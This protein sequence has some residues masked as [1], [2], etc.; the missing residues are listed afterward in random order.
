MTYYKVFLLVLTFTY[1]HEIIHPQ[2]HTTIPCIQGDELK[3]ASTYLPELLL[4]CT[5]P[6]DSL[7]DWG[8]TLS[9]CIS[10]GTGAE[11]NKGRVIFGIGNDIF[12]IL[13]R[14]SGTCKG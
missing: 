1:I 7:F 10:I 14:Y 13:K 5:I 9:V 2:G 12:K 3:M 11:M 8:V 6:V 4:S